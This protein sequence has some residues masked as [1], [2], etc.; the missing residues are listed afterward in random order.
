VLIYNPTRFSTAGNSEGAGEWVCDALSFC[1]SRRSSWQ[2]APRGRRFSR[3]SELLD[4]AGKSAATWTQGRDD[5]V[6]LHGPVHITLDRATLTADDAVVW[7]S[8]EAQENLNVLNAHFSLI[9]H[10][11][12]QQGPI[13]RSGDQLF[14]TG[15]VR[16]EK[17]RIVADERVARDDSN[18]PLFERAAALRQAELP[19][20]PPP[21][22][23][24]SATQTAARP[25]I[26]PRPATTRAAPAKPI[27]IPVVF[28]AQ[29]VESVY[30]ADGNIAIVL[31]GGVRLLQRRPNNE[32]IELSAQNAVLFTPLKSLRELTQSNGKKQG[33]DI[34]NAAYME[35]DVRI[36]F[37]GNRKNMPEERLTADHVYYEFATDRA[38][39]TNAIV[40]TTNPQSGSPVLMRGK[41]IRQLAQ[42]EYRGENSLLSNS[43]FALPTYCIAAERIYV[44]TTPTGDPRMGDVITYDATNMTMRSFGIP[45]F[46]W[47]HTAGEM[48]E[49]GFLLRAI[50]FGHDN[51]YGTFAEFTWGL[52]E[53]LGTI[54]P[55]DLDV[56]FRTDYF[57]DR[58]PGFGLNAKYGAGFVTDTTKQAWDFDGQFQSYILEDRGVDDVGRFPVRTDDPP[59]IRGTVL[60]E[61]DHYF[62][63]GWQA[64]ARVGFVSDATFLEQ[65]FRRDFGT[66]PPHDVMGYIKHT[67]DSEA[68]TFGANFQPSR[69]VTTSDYQEEQFEVEHL[70]QI[71]YYREGDALI[72]DHAT[73]FSD[74]IGG[75][76][77]FAKSKASLEEQ[78]FNTTTYYPGIPAEGYTGT[79]GQV[80]WR[81]DFR[82]QVD[83]PFTAGPLRIDP[84]VMGRYTEYS[85]SPQGVE[86]ARVMAGA[87]TRITTEFWKV[88]PAVES[89]FFDLHQLRHVVEPEINFF[90]S[91]MNVERNQVYVYDPAI[92]AINDISA[93]Q[94]ALHQR[95]ETKRGGPGQWR[96]VDV[97]SL[98]VELNYFA[99][100]P[101]TKFLDPYSFRGLYFSTYPEESVPRDSVNADASWRISDN[102]V[103]IGDM[104]YNL[105]RGS[106]ET[107]AIGILVRRDERLSYFIG[108]RYIDPLDSNVTSVHLD[109]EM[110]RKYFLDVDQEFDFTQGK[111]VYSGVALIRQF[112]TFFMAFRYY[113]DETTKQNG[114]SFNLYPSGLGVGL[115]TNAFNTFRK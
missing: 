98:N 59:S 47:P 10:A 49:H 42:G 113:Y 94:F 4:L 84:F 50:G 76:L 92:D 96:S 30:A 55:R 43:T 61:H 107:I 40:H 109:Y 5:V 22:T 73:F 105:D 75:G 79:P 36:N 9:G 100:K 23:N 24:P 86:R 97:F 20:I 88:D 91:A 99:N 45:F 28:E 41:I 27:E 38:V 39:L 58:G 26:V 66:G 11:S 34:I 60:W 12:L 74:N 54:P 6:L 108:N 63:D 89:V 114:F 102:T 71:G 111:N 52:F 44:R 13:T 46:Y 51:D 48:T 19:A 17:I 85:T 83:W 65:W 62:P 8:P 32:M 81:G 15:R 16:G 31:K 25:G 3:P 53:T 35:G 18:T 70:P 90:T 95:W 112:D 78:G 104:S 7:L 106:L 72:G 57:S 80:V 37:A 93:A 87:G 1:S 69:L 2:Q 110:T 101:A 82:Q 56:N 67:Q 64:Q 33:N 29:N 68:F 21:G 14:V 103:V 115:D 77:H